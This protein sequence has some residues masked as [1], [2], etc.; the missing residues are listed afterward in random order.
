MFGDDESKCLNRTQIE[1]LYR[2]YQPT[3][4]NGTFVYDAYQP[5]LE[6]RV[7]TLKGT[8]GKAQSWFELAILKFPQLD[9]TFDA[10]VN[11]TLDDILLGEREN[12]GLSNSEKTVRT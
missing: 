8:A 6:Q 10:F 11:V 2:I 1:N 9:K 12:P 7:S 4:I 3:I 5:G